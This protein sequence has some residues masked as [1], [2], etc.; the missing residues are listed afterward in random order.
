M[1]GASC[2]LEVSETV[3]TKHKKPEETEEGMATASSREASISGKS[4]ESVRIESRLCL[5]SST[6]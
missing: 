1:L 5:K 4:V 3:L 2:S 6:S